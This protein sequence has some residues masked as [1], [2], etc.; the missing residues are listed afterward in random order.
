MGTLDALDLNNLVALHVLLEERHV[1]RAARRLGPSQSSMS[2]RLAQ[3]RE[4]VGDPLFVRDRAH[5]LLTPRAKGLAEPLAAALQSLDSLL[6]PAPPFDPATSDMSVSLAMPDLLA[7]LAADLLAALERQAPRASA[8]LVHIGPDLGAALASGDPSM[9]L[10]PAPLV[11]DSTVSK[12]VGEVR[13]GVV[14]RQ[15]H[16]ALRGPLTTSAWLGYG[17]VVVRFGNQ[18]SN[19]VA[20]ELARRGLQRRVGLEVPS[21][22]TGLLALT[23]SDLLMNAPLPLVAQVARALRLRVREAPVPL[24]RVRFALLWHQRFQLD[25][26]HHWARDLIFATARPLFGPHAGRARTKRGTRD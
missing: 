19:V 3:L 1:T 11:P 23:N 6:S 25:P 21:F 7:P 4:A 9:A 22:L 16:P 13:F 20:E 2:H 12:Q 5:L 10:A 24:P 14:G 8:R 15:A 17:H 18:Q 26:A